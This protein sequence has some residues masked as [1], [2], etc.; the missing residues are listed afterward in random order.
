MRR[1]ILRRFEG[2]E[3]FE[4]AER[5]GDAG[6]ETSSRGAWLS[7]RPGGREGRGG[8]APPPPFACPRPGLAR[9]PGERCR[10]G[11]ATGPRRAGERG[12]GAEL[13]INRL[14][15]LAGLV[16]RAWLVDR[17]WQRGRSLA[18]GGRRAG[19]ARASGHDA[20]GGLDGGNVR[21]CTPSVSPKR[22]RVPLC[23]TTVF[24]S[25]AALLPEGLKGRG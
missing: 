20:P 11:L 18:R 12:V 1:L 15:D 2:S 8:E 17:W 13:D 4:A 24:H 9:G 16:A 19:A 7:R 25:L 10:F 3:L 21:Y 23:G 22:E 6:G 5:S 14:L